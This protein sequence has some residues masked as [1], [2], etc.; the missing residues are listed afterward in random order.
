MARNGASHWE[1]RGRKRMIMREGER[2]KKKD[3]ADEGV[4]EC[5]ERLQE[6]REL[7]RESKRVHRE[8]TRAIQSVYAARERAR[9]GVM[10]VPIKMQSSSNSNQQAACLQA[11]TNQILAC[12]PV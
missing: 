1:E 4:T 5:S 3:G 10:S 12:M 7:C 9:V 2:G 8:A 11:S 6:S